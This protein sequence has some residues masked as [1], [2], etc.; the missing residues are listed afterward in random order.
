M[1]PWIPDSEGLWETLN[2]PW[3]SLSH[4]E[5]FLYSS[6]QLPI[7][8][9]QPI[10]LN[11][12]AGKRGNLFNKKVT[13]QSFVLTALSFLWW[14]FTQQNSFCVKEGKERTRAVKFQHIL[15]LELGTVF[16]IPVTSGIQGKG[17]MEKRN[18]VIMRGKMK[19]PVKINPDEKVGKFQNFLASFLPFL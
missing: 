19:Y 4:A 16:P 14:D 15:I 6:C 1:F 3:S 17:D 13:N 10:F 7:N 12:K 8:L 18:A 2:T 11:S 9:S 5:I